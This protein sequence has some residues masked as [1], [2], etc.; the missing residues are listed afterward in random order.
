MGQSMR[1]KREAACVEVRSRCV[2]GSSFGGGGSMCGEGEQLWTG[3]EQACE[4]RGCTS[5][6][7]AVGEL[8]FRPNGPE[9]EREEQVWFG[10]GV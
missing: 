3:T 6:G 1:G 8:G 7:W 5:A 9:H 4:T 2:K 10:A